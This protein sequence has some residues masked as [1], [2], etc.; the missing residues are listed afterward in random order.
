MIYIVFI[1]VL[2][3]KDLD[4]LDVP[5]IQIYKTDAVFKD[6]VVLVKYMNTHKPTLS[7]DELVKK[8]MEFNNT[9][10]QFYKPPDPIDCEDPTEYIKWISKDSEIAQKSSDIHGYVFQDN[11]ESKDILFILP[12]EPGSLTK[13][14]L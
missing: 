5:G 7:I 14:V 13:N 2:W 11:F 6:C 4:L 12:F 10:E 8:V 1:L 3:I 9:N